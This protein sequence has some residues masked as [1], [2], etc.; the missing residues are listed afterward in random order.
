MKRM[1]VEELIEEILTEAKFF[2]AVDSKFLL[3]ETKQKFTIGKQKFL[4]IEINEIKFLKQHSRNLH[5]LLNETTDHILI[6]LSTVDFD[7][8]GLYT[9]MALAAKDI[10]SIIDEYSKRRKTYQHNLNQTNKGIDLLMKA[11]AGILD[12]YPEKFI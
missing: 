1:T 11:S 10:S 12:K 5:F 4:M 3:R 7:H 6:S 9:D 2:I 8:S